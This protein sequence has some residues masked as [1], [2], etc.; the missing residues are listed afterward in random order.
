MDITVIDLLK[1]KTNNIIDIR[2]TNEYNNGHLPNAKNI[3]SEKLLLNP[4]LY[5]NK[6]ETYY[7]Y[8]RCGMTSTKICQHLIN[9]NYKVINV[10]GGYQSYLK[11]I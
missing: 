10:I 7:I 4:E 3:P 11:I 1:L 9:K 6:K 8:C 5:L 2:S